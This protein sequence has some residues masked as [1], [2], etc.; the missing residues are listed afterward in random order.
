M[1]DADDCE[2]K[3]KEATFAC[4]TE[5]ELHEWLN[6]IE[7]SKLRV[8]QTMHLG[9]EMA[10][11]LKNFRIT[12]LNRRKKVDRGDSLDSFHAAYKGLLSKVKSAGDAMK[13]EDWF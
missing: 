6:Q 1:G 3:R 2:D 5:A 13:E 8:M 9:A 12:V 4:D 11:E 7:Q 10:R